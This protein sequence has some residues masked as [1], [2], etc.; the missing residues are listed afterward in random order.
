[1]G[2]GDI[3]VANQGR[4]A[5]TLR[6]LS[7]SFP[8]AVYDREGF[9]FD[10][11]Q[12]KSGANPGNIN[13]VVLSFDEFR[14]TPKPAN[15]PAA[16][17]WAYEVSA[18]NGDD[19]TL[20]RGDA[21]TSLLSIDQ[22]GGVGRSKPAT[23]WLPDQSG[24][25]TFISGIIAANPVN[26]R[27]MAGV[28]NNQ[29]VTLTPMAPTGGSATIA[30][31]ITHAADTYK[32]DVVN[33][34]LNW[35]ANRVFSDEP[36][37]PRPSKLADKDPVSPDVGADAIAQVN[38]PGTLF[39]VA[40]GN[41]ASNVFDDSPGTDPVLKLND[42]LRRQG[43][44]SEVQGSDF[45]PYPCR[46]KNGGRRSVLE[47]PDGTYDRG[48]ILC[49]GASNWYGEPT[50]FTNW[51]A[52]V[53]D[54]MAPGENVIGTDNDGR[55]FKV[56]D[57]TSFAAPVV[58]GIA[59]MIKQK[60][61][62]INEA[63]IVKC[64]ILSSA[65][66]RPAVISGLDFGTSWK[67]PFKYYADRNLLGDEPGKLPVSKKVFTVTGMAQ[68]DEAL[69]AAG[70][71]WSRYRKAVRKNTAKPRCV[72]RRAQSGLFGKG[73]WVDAPLLGSGY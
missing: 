68:A 11:S 25:G 28:I 43:R 34:S 22:A 36:A 41:E 66:T 69:S 21:Y 30:A 26:E 6:T 71:L 64:A 5:G 67:S 38:N 23:K 8:T 27:G 44:L 52:G 18:R 59:A 53:V 19:F 54:L 47:M 42:E 46:P 37:I 63:S 9:V 39:V 57:G 14:V 2:A 40:A 49:A 55:S 10:A 24:H 60:Y 12:L 32:L 1:M 58:T 29:S 20:R 45:A 61:P 62:G 17:K 73:K 51:G 31:A 33:I 15:A 48:N 72:Q 35:G 65:T 7:I 4:R 16:K 3:K 70:S 50:D 13:S 56:K